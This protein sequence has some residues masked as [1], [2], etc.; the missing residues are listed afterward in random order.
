MWPNI[1]Q[2]AVY[3]C[4]KSKSTNIKTS[5]YVINFATGAVNALNQGVYIAMNGRIFA[6]GHVRK[7]REAKCFET[8]LPNITLE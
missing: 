3:K 5:S 7:N 8:T 4:T 6:A 1:P 2:L